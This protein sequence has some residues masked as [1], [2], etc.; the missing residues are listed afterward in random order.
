MILSLPPLLN[1][2]LGLSASPSHVGDTAPSGFPGL[3]LD[4]LPAIV[5]VLA[6]TLP[7]VYS[8]ST[9]QFGGVSFNLQ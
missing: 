6:G 2:L 7:I 9:Y 5:S 4:A 8:N 1:E 3:V